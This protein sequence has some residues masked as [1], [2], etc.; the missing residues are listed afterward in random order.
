[1][2]IVYRSVGRSDASSSTEDRAIPPPIE[3]FRPVVSLPNE[4]L[5]GLFDVVCSIP[6]EPIRKSVLADYQSVI[7]TIL[8]G[9]LGPFFDPN[10]FLFPANIR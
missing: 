2:V 10:S 5:Y 7:F 8:T 1:V 3:N 4:M 9:Y 6:K